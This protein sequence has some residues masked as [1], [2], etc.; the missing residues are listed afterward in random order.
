MFYLE[1]DQLIDLIERP[2]FRHLQLRLLECEDDPYC[3]GSGAMLF[4]TLKRIMMLLPQSTSYMILQE[5]LSSV[6]RYRQSAVSLNKARSPVKVGSETDVFVKQIVKARRLH[7]W[8]KWRMIRAESL[9]EES[10]GAVTDEQKFNAAQQRRDW[11]GYKN[12]DDERETKQKIK[13]RMLN[14]GRAELVGVYEG[15]DEIEASRGMHR[16]EDEEADEECEVCIGDSQTNASVS[17]KQYERKSSS[18]DETPPQ[19]REFWANR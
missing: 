7:V 12:E 1:I 10:C 14:S 6:A 5:R 15:L 11:L 18:N 9:E 19:W 4:L 16:D 3:E 13:E 8:A 2:I 17:K